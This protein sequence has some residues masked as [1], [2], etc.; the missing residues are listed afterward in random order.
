MRKEVFPTT[1]LN[2][3]DVCSVGEI[4]YKMIDLMFASYAVY[5][6]LIKDVI[7]KIHILVQNVMLLQ[8][9]KMDLIML[10]K[11]DFMMAVV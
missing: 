10:K 1:N 11:L 7:N 4:T 9:R 2:Y 5:M 8:R 3:W 6:V